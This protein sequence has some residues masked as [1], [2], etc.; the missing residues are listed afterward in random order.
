MNPSDRVVAA[1][2]SSKITFDERGNSDVYPRVFIVIVVVIILDTRCKSR[3]S[4][5]FLFSKR[6]YVRY[7][8]RISIR[9]EKI[10]SPPISYVYIYIDTYIHL[11]VGT[12]FSCVSCEA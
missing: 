9:L 1:F 8:K 4:H 10:L 12:S 5:V 6:C 11:Y 2:A 3:S 7:G